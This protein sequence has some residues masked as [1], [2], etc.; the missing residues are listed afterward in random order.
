M[1]T[2]RYIKNGMARDWVVAANKRHDKL[3]RSGTVCMCCA[4]SISNQRPKDEKRS[5]PV[6]QKCSESLD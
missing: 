3:M 2:D 6:C 1:V 5:G 4:Q